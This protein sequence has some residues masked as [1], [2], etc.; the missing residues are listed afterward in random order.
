MQ[1]KLN[2]GDLQDCA[3]SNHDILLQRRVN[4]LDQELNDFDRNFNHPI[5]S[6]LKDTKEEN[7]PSDD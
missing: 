4:M 6:T 2:S 1:L 3:L 7:Q 5:L